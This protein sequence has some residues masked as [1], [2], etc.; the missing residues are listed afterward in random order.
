MPAAAVLAPAT[1][2][3]CDTASCNGAVSHPSTCRCSCNG[4]GHGSDHATGRATGIA[5]L[6][7][8]YVRPGFTQSMLDAMDDEPF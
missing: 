1:L 6:Q 7:T 5:H 3:V 2:H 4:T 8:R